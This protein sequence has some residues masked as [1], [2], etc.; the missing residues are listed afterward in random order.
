VTRTFI[1]ASSAGVWYLGVYG[2]SPAGYIF[3]HGAQQE[4]HSGASRLIETNGVAVTRTNGLVDLVDKNIY[5]QN[6]LLYGNDSFSFNDSPSSIT[7][8][9]TSA[10]FRDSSWTVSVVVKF[11]VVNKGSDNG[12]LSHVEVDGVTNKHLNLVERAGKIYYGFYGNDFQTNMSVSANV[13]YLINFTYNPVTLKQE[14]YINGVLAQGRTAS[15]AYTGVS[16]TITVAS[17]LSGELPMMMI[18]DRVLSASEINILFVTN[19]IKFG[20]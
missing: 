1:A 10:F 4:L 6:S 8:S 3:L 7:R 12:I 9:I 2:T 14:I 5:T 17:C 16:S 13:P 11:Y 15:T 19:K 18:H 20:L